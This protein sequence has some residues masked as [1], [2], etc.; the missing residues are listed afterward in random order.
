MDKI[1]PPQR[2]R[3]NI[4]GGIVRE[5][6][7]RAK[8]YFLISTSIL[9]ISLVGVVVSARYLMQ[10]SHESGFYEYF[11][12]LFS[13]DGTVFTYWK[14]LSYSL[15]ETVPVVGIILF[16]V[17]LGFLIWSGANTFTNVRRFAITA[18]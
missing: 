1:E 11:S 18:N 3:Q 14:E 15:V 12:L 7:R 17:T 16:L 4:L 6:I 9:P 5:E 13:G 8:N 10:G 2:L